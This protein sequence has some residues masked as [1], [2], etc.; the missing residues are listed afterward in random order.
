MSWHS[1]AKA[2]VL[3][4]KLFA[5]GD[6][7]LQH[8]KTHGALLNTAEVLIRTKLLVSP[9]TLTEQL[10]RLVA[11]RP[12]QA[13][14]DA[15]GFVRLHRHLNDATQLVS[16]L[17]PDDEIL[18]QNLQVDAL[19]LDFKKGNVPHVAETSQ[20]LLEALRQCTLADEWVH[21]RDVYQQVASVPPNT[22]RRRQVGSLLL[23]A[24]SIVLLVWTL[25]RALL[26]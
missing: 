2:A 12:V 13:P 3:L 21:L 25:F 26:K 8:F 9:E 23:L 18:E 15:L 11:V 22:P 10:N 16:L 5:R 17:G 6:N 14:P 24:A 19:R 1:K 7:Q 4:V 20:P